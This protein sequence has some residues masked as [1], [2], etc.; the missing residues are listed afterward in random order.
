VRLVSNFKTACTLSWCVAIAL[1]SAV[2][3]CSAKV[4]GESARARANGW[5]YFAALQEGVF[6][7]LG[8]GDVDFGAVLSRL[9]ATGFSG[10]I[11]V[12]Q[13]VIPGGGTPLDSARRNR[14]YLRSLG[15]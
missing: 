10:W 15:L 7:E 5:D 2:S 8:A 4:P 3:R 11:V 1:L 14:A 13:D 12:E 9:R 6:C